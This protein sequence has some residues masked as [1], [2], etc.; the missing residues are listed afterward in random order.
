MRSLVEKEAPAKQ[1]KNR[2]CTVII[3]P[4]ASLPRVDAAKRGLILNVCLPMAMALC[5]EFLHLPLPVDP[6]MYICTYI[7]NMN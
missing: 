4:S 5:V 3:T 6:S 1:G 2:Y 7:V